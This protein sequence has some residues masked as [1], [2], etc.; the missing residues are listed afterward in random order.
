L[1][2]LAETRRP[3]NLR[4]DLPAQPCRSSEM[5]L[6]TLPVP[7][8]R[9]G[10]QVRRFLPPAPLLPPDPGPQ[11]DYSGSPAGNRRAARQNLVPRKLRFPDLVHH[12][13]GQRRHFHHFGHCPARLL[14]RERRLEIA[15]AEARRRALVPEFAS[16]FRCRERSR[17]GWP[18]SPRLRELVGD[19]A[20]KP[21]QPPCSRARPP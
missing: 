8:E 3:R 11:L 14:R 6:M 13:S 15:C 18:A 4:F 5:R 21:P 17:P 12:H 19:F 7:E 16:C 1:R 2:R 10:R 9:L 20:S